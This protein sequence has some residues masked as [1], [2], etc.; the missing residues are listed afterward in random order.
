MPVI[1]RNFK[2]NQG[3]SAQPGAVM[4]VGGT[5][6]L[7]IGQQ[8]LNNQI[9]RLTIVRRA[10]VEDGHWEMFLEGTGPCVKVDLMEAGYR[11]LYG[12][13]I[14]AQNAEADVTETN[15]T[16]RQM[17][18]C[19]VNVSAAQGDWTGTDQYNCQDFVVEFLKELNVQGIAAGNANQ[20][21]KSLKYELMRYVRKNKGPD[22]WKDRETL[23]VEYGVPVFDPTQGPKTIKA[24]SRPDR[25]KVIR[26]LGG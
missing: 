9:T 19:L 21:S 2:T 17:V 20:I 8:A 3:G 25:R 10:D 7:H 24:P 5:L 11:I 15:A 6:E 1:I 13:A 22:Y 18:Q 12:A 16:L 14:P 26:L 23:R 4:A